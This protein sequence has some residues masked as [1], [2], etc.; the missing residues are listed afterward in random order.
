MCSAGINLSVSL[1]SSSLKKLNNQ[2]SKDQSLPLRD[3][4]R[5]R[6]SLVKSEEDL[7][8]KEKNFFPYWNESSKVMSGWLEISG[9]MSR[10]CIS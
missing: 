3:S 6:K 4:T 2:T 5:K 8:L 9:K 10:K 1:D 7:T